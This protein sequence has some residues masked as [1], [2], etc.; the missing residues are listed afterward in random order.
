VRGED[1]AHDR[2]MHREHLGITGVAE[3]L[4]Q[5]RAALEVAEDE[6]DGAGWQVGHGSQ[7]SQASLSWFRV[8]PSAV[9]PSAVRPSA[10]PSA[11]R[12]GGNSGQ[13]ERS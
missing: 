2:A 12:C 9:R 3:L 5:A 6:R 4:E 11:A 13:A 1:L 7:D 8:R 10:R